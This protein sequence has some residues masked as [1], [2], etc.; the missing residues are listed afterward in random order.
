MLAGAQ[1]RHRLLEDAIGKHHVRGEGFSYRLNVE[2]L[3]R[4]ELIDLDIV[5]FRL[6]LSGWLSRRG[7]TLRD[8]KS[9]SDLTV[10]EHVAVVK[11]LKVVDP[12]HVHRPSEQL[13]KLA[14]CGKRVCRAKLVSRRR[15][16]RSVLK[17][18]RQFL[19]RLRNKVPH[20]RKLASCGDVVN[21]K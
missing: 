19:S 4:G 5:V 9:L 1:G 11:A 14:Y 7:G 12:D 2:T 21:S 16:E 17:Q 8:L 15:L 3:D 13:G 10:K 18:L 6:D 20:G